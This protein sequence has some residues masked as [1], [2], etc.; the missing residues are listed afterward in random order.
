[1]ILAILATALLHAQNRVGPSVPREFSYQGSVAVNGQPFTGEGRF[2]FLLLAKNPLSA[3]PTQA[4]ATVTAAGT[5]GEITS[6]RVDEPGSGYL[7]PPTITVTDSAIF[8]VGGSGCELRANLS[9]Q[10]EISS[11]TVVEGGSGY[12][13]PS[14]E[15]SPP[16]PGEEAIWANDS[17]FNTALTEPGSFVTISVQDGLF[18]TRLGGSGMVSL[19]SYLDHFRPNLALRVW[20][21]APDQPFEQ[22]SPDTQLGSVPFALMSSRVVSPG[23]SASGSNAAALG[24]GNSASGP[25][26]VAMGTGTE[27]SGSNSFSGGRFSVASGSSSFAMGRQNTAS[28]DYSTATGEGSVASGTSS[29]AMGNGTVASGS[30]STAIGTGTE[31]RGLQSTAI[32]SANTATGFYST[33]FG[34]FTTAKG[35]SST[36]MGESTEA[37][38]FYST[39]MGKGT[40][41]SGFYSTAMGRETLA[42]SYG[43]VALGIYSTDYTPS[44]AFESRPSDRLFVLG[45]GTGNGERSDALIIEKSGQTFFYSDP[46][47]TNGFFID[48]YATIIENTDTTSGSDVLALKSQTENPG[49]DTNYLS[50][51]D[52]SS[53]SSGS[54]TVLGEI[55]GNGAGGVRFQSNGAD[56]AEYLPPVDADETLTPGDLVAV[57]SGKITR[58]TSSF[59]QLMVISTNPIIV[60][61]RPANLPEDESGYYKVAFIGQVPVKVIGAVNSGDYLLASG[62]HDGTAVAK[63]ASALRASDRAHI[64]GRAWDSS[65]E[66]GEKLINAAVGLD[67]GEA[68]VG[69]IRNLRNQVDSLESR[70][71]R[72]EQRATVPDGATNPQ[73]GVVSAR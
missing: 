19:P 38:G 73:K 45:N 67:L 5:N 12:E 70:L 63:P 61:N 18:S 59:D 8:G 6:V 54:G 16:T 48:N 56:Y 60:G 55:D 50:F 31:A 49:S 34:I 7:S 2:K 20:F 17:D 28:G 24:S 42:R 26:S 14:V 4:T 22:L 57:R 32:G 13:L 1:M 11:I 43:E 10:G 53:A 29:T 71:T 21:A 37:S 66:E 51:F 58:D 27:A 72:L 23:S 46:G 41:A 39:A 33:A 25:D 62:Q 64:I 9:P 15:I 52:G 40:I 47:A 65:A 30:N 3:S 68:L 44:S 69:E 36:A 35:T